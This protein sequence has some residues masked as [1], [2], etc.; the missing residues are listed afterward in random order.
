MD[1]RNRTG[2]WRSA[3]IATERDWTG[4]WRSAWIAG[5]HGNGDWWVRDMRINV[6]HGRIVGV[7]D[8]LAAAIGLVDNQSILEYQIRDRDGRT[9]RGYWWTPETDSQE[10]K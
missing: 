7:R 6:P 5:P 4:R 9:V 1:E 2:R 10:A 3:W 8:T